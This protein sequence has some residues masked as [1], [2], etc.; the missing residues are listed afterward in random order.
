MGSEQ[1]RLL[2]HRGRD[3]NEPTSRRKISSEVE[4]R[5]QDINTAAT[6]NTPQKKSGIK[7]S[8]NL[9]EVQPDIKIHACTENYL[10]PDHEN[11][12]MTPLGEVTDEQLLA[13]IVRRKIDIHHNVTE[14]L[15]RETYVFETHIGHGASGEVFLV[16]N[17][18]T[19]EKYA[20]KV[21]RKDTTINDS[22]SMSTEIEIMKR[23]RHRNIVA[24]YELYEVI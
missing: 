6:S 3:D 11:A 4:R 19:N 5:F 16:S 21:V 17:R 2:H 7:Q 22:K 14:S 15:V 10:D 20:C 12:L 23:I 8:Y 24:M 13:E 1:S 18:F 9:H